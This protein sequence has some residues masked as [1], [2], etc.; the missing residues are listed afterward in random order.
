MT[1]AIA[2]YFPEDT[3]ITK[4]KGGLLLWIELFESIDSFKVFSEALKQ[5]VSILPGLLFS[6]SNRFK[7]C[8]RINCGHPWRDKLEHGIATLGKII[9]QSN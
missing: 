6:N 9:K 5:R 4:P 8:I 3:K 7:N 2:R 1:E